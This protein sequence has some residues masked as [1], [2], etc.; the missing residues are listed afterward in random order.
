MTINRASKAGE[1]RGNQALLRLSVL[2]LFLA[3][4]PSC[5]EP[6][7]TNLDNAQL[8]TMLDQNVPLYDVRLP[9]E[10]H[11]TGVIEGSRQLTFIDNAGRVRPDFF[12]RFSTEVGKDD[13]VIVICHSGSRTR[14][15]AYHLVEQMGYTQVFNVRKG[16]N[17]WISEQRPVKHLASQS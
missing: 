14:T 3:L 16:I 6:P 5:S 17:R 1:R 10:W 2:L 9:Q 4:L 8:Q 12:S 11:Q 15:L 7:Y 13:P